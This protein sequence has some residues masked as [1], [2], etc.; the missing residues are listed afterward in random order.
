MLPIWHSVAVHLTRAAVFRKVKWQLKKFSP[1][2]FVP[3]F[4]LLSRISHIHLLLL[5]LNAAY[6]CLI[7]KNI[8]RPH[9]HTPQSVTS[10]VTPAT[11]LLPLA[12]VLKFHLWQ[13][14]QE[15]MNCWPHTRSERYLLPATCYLLRL[16]CVGCPPKKN[17]RNSLTF[18]E[19]SLRWGGWGFNYG[20]RVKQQTHCLNPLTYFQNINDKKNQNKSLSPYCNLNT[21]CLLCHAQHRR[22]RVRFK[23]LLLPFNLLFHNFKAQI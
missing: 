2:R 20:M 15:H 13:S 11:S 21:T 4:F 9:T 12:H 3:V 8:F 1:R 16:L 14:A 7:C 10:T 17:V 19:H 5:F 18:W 22:V 23:L 6:F